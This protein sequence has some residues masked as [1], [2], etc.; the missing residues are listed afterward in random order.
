MPGHKTKIT[1]DQTETFI[2]NL[3]NYPAISDK[4]NKIYKN[5]DAKALKFNGGNCQQKLAYQKK[6]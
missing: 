5:I 4:N 1:E 3:I 2:D 6:I